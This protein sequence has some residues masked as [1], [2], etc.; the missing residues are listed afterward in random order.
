VQ[1][2]GAAAFCTR[3]NDA[4]DPA[5]DLPAGSS[6]AAA[7]WGNK[8]IIQKIDKDFRAGFPGVSPPTFGGIAPD[9][10]LAY[11]YLQA[12]VKFTIPYF[13]ETK[14]FSFTDAAGKISSVRA[15]GVREEDDYAYRELRGQPK[16]L[17]VDDN[18]EPVDFAIDLCSNSKDVQVVVACTKRG[19]T[20]AAT[21][22][23]LEAKTAA[24]PK[25]MR[26]ALGIND[27]L[28]VPRM[29]WR[30]KHHFQ[31]V[32]GK[33]FANAALSQQ[34]MD[35]A[36]EELQFRL[37][38]GGMELRAE[39]KHMMKPVPKHYL[40]NRPFLLYAKKRDAD[41]PFFVMWVE[42]AELLTAVSAR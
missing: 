35:V 11:V 28:L 24:F 37:D 6:Y 34:R 4:A 25:E 40:A 27:V 2:N 32:E 38:K 31:E 18:F 33:A 9:S 19:T 10:Y 39:A 23:A 36:T 3:L 1:L 20:L 30:I 14:P 12:S 13:E 41:H 5:A 17:Y 21:L 26:K 42:N 8:G 15:F 7:G 29:D 22:E 16:L